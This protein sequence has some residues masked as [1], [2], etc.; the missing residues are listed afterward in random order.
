MKRIA[1][2]SFYHEESS[3]C[4][5]KYMAKSPDVR[6][7]YYYI[8]N[9]SSKGRV[10]GFEFW[11]VNVRWG[12]QELRDSEIPEICKYSQGSN[13]HYYLIT[14]DSASRRY[15]LLGLDKLTLWNACRIIK[16][17]H[18]DAIDIVGQVGMVRYCHRYLKG[19]NVTHTFH[20]IGSHQDDIASTNVIDEVIKDGD[21]VILHSRATYNRYIG[22]PGADKN[23]TTIIPFGKFETNLLYAKKV[24]LNIPLDLTKPT[25]LF[26]G[27]RKPYKGLDILRRAVE[28]LKSIENQYNIV[29]AGGGEDENVEFFKSLKN[30][31]VLNRFLSNDEMMSFI[32]LSSVIVLPYHTASQTGIISTCSLYAKPVIATKVGAFPEMVID[33]KN[34]VLVDPEN[35]EAFATVMKDCIVNT[36]MLE[37]LSNGAANY[38]RNDIFDWNNIAEKTLS[39]ILN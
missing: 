31:F 25:F 33:G 23:L 29:I 13:I 24:E 4:L 1:I 11:R 2:I 35:P 26:F 32:E 5:A 7:D 15:S 21:K 17:R 30:C 14:F 22:L 16:S 3:I 10:P 18:Y 19:Q 38:G 6:V 9:P 37:H 8:N 39:F 34:G 12:I 28:R 36:A 27:A 20:E